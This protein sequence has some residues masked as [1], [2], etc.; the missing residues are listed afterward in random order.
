MQCDTHARCNE[1]KG[2]APNGTTLAML[3]QQVSALRVGVQM[4]LALSSCYYV[5]S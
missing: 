3:S 4:P 5:I 1:R 2:G